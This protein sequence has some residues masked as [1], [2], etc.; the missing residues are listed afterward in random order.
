[1]F[2]NY[3]KEN[4]KSHDYVYPINSNDSLLYNKFRNVNEYNS[5][6]IL[7]LSVSGFILGKDN[8]HESYDYTFRVLVF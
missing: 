3:Y 8:Y 4:L 5:I 1:M 2:L 6:L 7:I